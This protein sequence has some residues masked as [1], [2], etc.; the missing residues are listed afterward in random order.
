MGETKYGYT[1]TIP[2]LRQRDVEQFKAAH[3][4]FESPSAITSNG[5]TVR[6]AAEMGWLVKVAASDPDD[7]VAIGNLT[8]DAVGEL[9]PFVI[10]WLSTEIVGAYSTSFKPPGE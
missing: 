9:F 3:D 8:E 6:V 10:A 4:V 1:L 2:R 5:N 7:D